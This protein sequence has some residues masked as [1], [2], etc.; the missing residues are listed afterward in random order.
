MRSDARRENVS[1]GLGLGYGEDG[2]GIEVESRRV[3]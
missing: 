1:H 2:E 3:G